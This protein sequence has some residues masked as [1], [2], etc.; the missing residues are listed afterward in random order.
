MWVGGIFAAA[1]APPAQ[2]SDSLLVLIAGIII[3]A[4]VPLG[5][6]IV[7]IVRGRN[8]R[9]TAS[10][11]APVPV[12]PA[13]VPKDVVLYERTAKHNERFRQKDEA[14]H[15]RDLMLKGHGEKLDEHGDLLEDHIRDIRQIKK[16]LGLYDA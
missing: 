7:E 9:T 8:S 6:V 14:D 15:A 11:P 10:P 13:S 2:N 3:A 4:M 1:E 12:A 5:S 16:H